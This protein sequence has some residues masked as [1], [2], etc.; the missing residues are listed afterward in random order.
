MIF[1]SDCDLFS[2]LKSD[3]AFVCSKQRNNN[4]P[5]ESYDDQSR[6]TNSGTGPSPTLLFASKIDEKNFSMY[7][8]ITGSTQNVEAGMS[9]ATTLKAIDQHPG[10]TNKAMPCPNSS[11]PNLFS[12][13]QSGGPGG[14]V[15]QFTHRLASDAENTIY[16]PSG[17]SQTCATEVTTTAND[18][19]KE[20]EL[21]IEGGAI[22]ISSVYSKG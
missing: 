9:T 6:G 1:H 5:S 2:Y 20:K 4:R 21:T 13:G 10:I 16:K 7:P 15:S 11:Q 3:V 18:K 14:V 12:P 22:S 19:M 17:Q 8:T